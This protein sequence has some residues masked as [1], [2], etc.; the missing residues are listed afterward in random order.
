MAENLGEE[1]ISE[2]ALPKETFSFGQIKTSALE[3]D[4]DEDEEL[5]LNLGELDL[6]SQDEFILDEVNEHIQANLEDELVKEAL[7]K[8]VDLRQYSKQIEADLHNVENS[9]IGDYI[10]ESDN[11]ASLHKQIA[12]CDTILERMEDMLTNFQQDL[13]SISSEIQTL[14]EQSMSMNVKLKNR[15]AIRGELSQFVDEMLV[16]ETMIR[17]ITETPVTEQ[18]FIENLHEL[19]HK[20]NFVKEQAFNDFK[21]CNDVK[22]VLDKLKLKAVQKIREF[23]LPKV[24][25]FRKPMT[26]YQIPQNALLKHRYFNEFLMVHHRQV[27]REIKDE[28]VDTISKVYFSYFKA[29]ISK[30]TKLQFL[31]LFSSRVALRNRSTIF[32]LGNRGN[33][34]T[35]ELE[36]PII[37]PH[38][39]Q[40]NDRKYPS[41]SLFRSQHYALLDN[42]CREYLFLVDFFN[43]Q[44]NPAKE[45]FTS[46]FG[47]TLSLLMKYW[48]TF[49]QSCYDAIGIFL[50]MH[51]IHRYRILMHKRTV[52]AL[53]KY[54]D[55]L[56]DMLWPRFT[57]VI[58]Q[59]IESIRL[60]DPQKMGTIDVQPHYITRRYAEFSAAIVSLNESFPDEK[61]NKLLA[62]LQEELQKFALRMAAEF[63]NRKEQ[64]IFL[65]NNYDMMLAVLKERTSEDSQETE[66]FQ[67]LLSARIQEF[68][69]EILSPG[70]GGMIAF[71]KDVEPQLERNQNQYVQADERRVGQIVRGFA[72]DWKR[73]IESINHDIM[74][75][76]SNLKNG[77]A[78]LQAAL[79]QLI[80]YY[81]RFQKVLSQPPFKKLAVRSELINIHHVMVEVKKHKTT[82]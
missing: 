35:S 51:I 66:S 16:S 44:G 36:E 64:L 72:T 14:Q 23:I 70:F 63:P 39:A 60:I 30:L 68:V 6:T 57:F 24:Y 32:T 8:G 52:P 12:A 42:G 11:I 37:V 54:L 7:E 18:S 40:K 76:F 21:C 25:Q 29:Y 15:Q 1:N 78:I 17:H 47:K 79:T 5:D 33:V 50:C 62:M 77:T 59:N 48:D 82:F 65:I 61:V 9:S 22:D 58:Q 73:G 46:V 74:R 75:S 71:V 2:N 56:L 43:V 55:T 4:E 80:Q 13:G 41:E 19:D 49:L 81:H 10:K 67:Q 26:N 27:A 69:E 38:A 45:I 53:D 20:I 31:R 34:L 28:Y 3:E